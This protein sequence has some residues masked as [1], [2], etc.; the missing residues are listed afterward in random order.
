MGQRTFSSGSIAQFIQ[1][2]LR[3]IRD[4]S[5]YTKMI[6]AF[7]IISLLAVGVVALVADNTV[8]G[9]LTKEV[10][11]NLHNVANLQA[12]SMSD[13]LSRKLDSLQRL[14]LQRTVVVELLLFTENV[15]YPTDAGK[16]PSYLQDLDRQWQ[17]LPNDDSLVQRRLANALSSELLKFQKAFSDHLALLVTNEYG[18]M[19]AA[20][21]RPRVYYHATE[22]WWQAAYH[23]GKGAIYI[24]TPTVD[25]QQ[26]RSHFDIAIPIYG[27]NSPKVIGILYAT[28]SVTFL[29]E[30]L[31]SVKLGQTGHADLLFPDG[32][33][34]SPT[35]NTLQQLD[36]ESHR[37]L[38]SITTSYTDYVLH[39]VPSFASLAP[40]VVRTKDQQALNLGWQIVAQQDQSEALAPVTAQRISFLRLAVGIA[41]TALLFALL[42]AAWLTAPIT[43]LTAVA[44]QITLG[45]SNIQA[46]V[47]AQD[48][49]GQLAAAFNQMTARLHKLNT[50]LEQRVM[51]RTAALVRTNEQLRLSKQA[52]EEAQEAAQQANQFK[53]QFLANMSHELRTP[54]NAINGFTELVLDEQRFGPLGDRR[55]DRLERVLANGQ[56]LLSLINDILDLSKIEAGQIDLHFEPTQLPPLVKSLM[57]T[58]LGLTKNKDIELELD[59]PPELPAVQIDPKRIRQVL[60]NLLSNAAK[61]TEHGT[62]NVKVIQLNQAFIQISVRDSGI[63]IAPEHHHLVFEEFRQVDNGLTRLHQGTGLGLPISKRLVEMHGGNM[64]LESASGE[65]STFSFT[66]PIIQASPPSVRE[67]TVAPPLPSSMPLIVAVDDDP[68]AQHLLKEYLEERPYQL[69]SI[70]DSRQA[71]AEIAQLQPQLVLLDIQ[72]PYLSGWQLLSLLR[73]TPATATLPIVMCTIVDGKSQGLALGANDYLIK[74]ISKP[75]ILSVIQRWTQPQGHI[76]IIDDDPDARQLLRLL[77]EEE[78]YQISEAVNGLVG[79]ERITQETPTLIILDLMMPQLDGFTVLERIRTSPDPAIRDLPVIVVT[80]K[81]LSTEEERWLLEQS[82]SFMHKA[83]LSREELLTVVTK[84]IQLITSP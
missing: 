72:M 44:Q 14:S 8:T 46:R 56:H 76:L 5:L 37:Q 12:L 54:L 28:Y 7:L 17:T 75:T 42:I 11:T 15:P 62:I 2:R 35:H 84:H 6:S 1:R 22:P 53:S 77:L 13:L 38:Q 78:Q 70:T 36:P 27:L 65:G 48:E 45:E 52:A 3:R 20:T 66:I 26:E 10:G 40:V 55:R 57:S 32:Q 74:P 19:V 31:A 29:S 4:S 69:H 24:G 9:T 64:W 71:L 58:A 47:E 60:L 59:C 79:L 25:Q 30:L 49:I 34:F 63:G 80:A 18:E 83:Q 82:L 33:L 16:I 43:R 67:E 50:E 21:E 81:E 51:D 41:G 61:F 68:D 73:S 39:G 23:D